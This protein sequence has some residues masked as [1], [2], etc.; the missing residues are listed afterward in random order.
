MGTEIEDDAVYIH[1]TTEYSK[2]NYKKSNHIARL[3]LLNK[4]F[5]PTHLA[6]N[7]IEAIAFH[8]LGNVKSVKELFSPPSTDDFDTLCQLIVISPILNLGRLS[9]DASKVNIFC[10]LY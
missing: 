10:Y 7:Q 8:L 9:K 5:D 3:Q 4:T 6:T 1:S 2:P